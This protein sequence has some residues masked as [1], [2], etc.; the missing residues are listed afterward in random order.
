MPNNPKI[1]DNIKQLKCSKK[2]TIQYAWIAK[3][4][5]SASEKDD[6]CIKEKSVFNM[7]EN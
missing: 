2:I 6:K 3:Y 7:A 1:L 4:S 5:T